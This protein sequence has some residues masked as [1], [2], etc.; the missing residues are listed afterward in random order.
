MEN[1]LQKID[2]SLSTLLNNKEIEI[3]KIVWHVNQLVAYPLTDNQ[4]EAWSKS[5]NKLIPS[6]DLK[7]LELLI[8]EMKVGNIDWDTR[9]GIQNLFVHLNEDYNPAPYLI[10]HRNRL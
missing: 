8:D 7:K 6:L 3:A 4:I 5:I 2:N 10:D 1:Q 9:K